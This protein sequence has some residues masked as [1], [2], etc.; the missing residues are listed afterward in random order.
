LMSVFPPWVPEW[1]A[2]LIGLA[3]ALYVL[4]AILSFIVRPVLRLVIA[5]RHRIKG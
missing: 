4:A 1:L 5:W 2:V 3:F